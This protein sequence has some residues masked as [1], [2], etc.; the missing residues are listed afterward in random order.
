MIFCGK[1]HV[2]CCVGDF[3]KTFKDFLWSLADLDVGF[4]VLRDDLQKRLESS[5]EV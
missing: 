1:R 2:C 4:C 5:T 3:L